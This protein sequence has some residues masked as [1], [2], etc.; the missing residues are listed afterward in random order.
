MYIIV[1]LASASVIWCAICEQLSAIVRQCFASSEV[2]DM[3]ILPFWPRNSRRDERFH[4]WP[5]INIDVTARFRE[6]APLAKSRF[7]LPSGDAHGRKRHGS[8]S[9]SSAALLR[10]QRQDASA[11][12]A[13]SDAIRN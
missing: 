1:V 13:R 11:A 4:A 3:V 9:L 10:L 2:V 12:G 7:L 5:L 6:K 8:R